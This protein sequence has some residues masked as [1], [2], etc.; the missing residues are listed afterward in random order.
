VPDREPN[1]DQP[2]A[3][4]EAELPAR[5]EQ[6][7]EWLETDGLGGFASGTVGLV[8]TRRYH[9]LLLTATKPPAGR[10]VLWNGFDAE[11]VTESG[12]FAISTQRYSPNAYSPDGETRLIRFE[13]DPW[14]RFTFALPDA[15]LIQEI[16][17]VHGTSCAVVSWRLEEI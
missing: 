5:R 6:S 4:S 7:R 13:S 16:F 14:P 8:R 17:L 9:A 2:V 12:T 15:Q 10:I 1:Q 11:V 3:A